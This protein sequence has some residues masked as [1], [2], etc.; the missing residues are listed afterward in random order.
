MTAE[1]LRL[2]RSSSSIHL[3]IPLLRELYNGETKYRIYNINYTFISRIIIIYD[4]RFIASCYNR[5]AMLC[6]SLLAAK[7][8]L[9]CK[10]E[11]AYIAS[12]TARLVQYCS[13]NTWR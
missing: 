6:A 12:N 10:L 13:T 4:S 5:F 3:F 9:M 7:L 1:K 2:V 8:D 11:L